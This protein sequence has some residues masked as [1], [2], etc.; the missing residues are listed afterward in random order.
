MMITSEVANEVYK[1][2]FFADKI[3]FVLCHYI[4]HSENYKLYCLFLVYI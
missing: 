1:N 4:I 2:T 3:T